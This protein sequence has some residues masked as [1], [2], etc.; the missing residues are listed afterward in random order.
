MVNKI[1]NDNGTFRIKINP[2]NYKGKI[3][4]NTFKE[5]ETV[6]EEFANTMIKNDEYFMLCDFIKLI[7]TTRFE[8][9][10]KS[11]INKEYDDTTLLDGFYSNSKNTIT[12]TSYE[13]LIHEL[14]HLSNKYKTLEDVER[15]GLEFNPDKPNIS[16]GS[17]VNEGLTELYHS[18]Y[19][20]KKEVDAYYNEKIIM[21]HVGLIIGENNLKKMRSRGDYIDLLYALSKYSSIEETLLFLD[22]VDNLTTSNIFSKKKVDLNTYLIAND[23][24]AYISKYLKNCYKNKIEIENLDKY[25]IYI[26]EDMV[27]I[28]TYK[29]LRIV[30]PPKIKKIVYKKGI[31]Q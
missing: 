11:F 5:I 4:N 7:K 29:P 27:P 30:K 25:S 21:K 12:Y 1:I 14:M 22:S 31:N 2:K 6:I 18:K 16:I 3:T 28:L 10:E 19:F 13:D 20:P 8:Y 24:L 15:D 26:T 9:S 17:G 23:S